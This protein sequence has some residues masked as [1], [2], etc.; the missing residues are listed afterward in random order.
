MNSAASKNRT[1]WGCILAS[2]TLLACN[3]GIVVG[4]EQGS[5]GSSA[6]GPVGETGGAGDL[7]TEGA[8]DYS[9]RPKPANWCW[10]MQD[11]SDSVLYEVDMDTGDWGARRYLAPH[12][13]GEVVNIA[14]LDNVLVWP[15]AWAMASYDLDTNV[16]RDAQFGPHLFVSNDHEIMSICPADSSTYGFCLYDSVD[17]IWDETPSGLIPGDEFAASVFALGDDVVY[18]AWHAGTTVDVHDKE[19][20]ALLRTIPLWGVSMSWVKGLAVVGNRL[21]RM[22]GAQ[23]NGDA[24]ARISIHDTESGANTGN[25]FLGYDS[26]WPG[27]DI[28]PAGLICGGKFD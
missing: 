24:G 26:R 2:C 19:T 18:A 10:F 20:G 12:P 28:H 13:P 25:V 15:T 5:G 22:D 1:G 16:F 23:D 4:A 11:M 21:L 9:L 8:S 17:A 6:D 27:G 3:T 7:S 14:V